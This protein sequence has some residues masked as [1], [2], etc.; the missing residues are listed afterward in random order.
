MR[1]CHEAHASSQSN[2]VVS[3]R[4]VIRRALAERVPRHDSL[5]HLRYLFHSALAVCWISS[6]TWELTE[7]IFAPML[8]NFYECWWDQLIYDILICNGLGMMVT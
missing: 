3:T 1:A 6:V 8:P 4:Q 2:P 5:A 7:I